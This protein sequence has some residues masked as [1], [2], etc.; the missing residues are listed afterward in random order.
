LCG[1]VSL[2]F[3][4]P[5]FNHNLQ[6]KLKYLISFIIM[7]WSFGSSAQCGLS[8]SYTIQD[9]F[10]DQADTTNI[11][12]LVSGAAINDLADPNQGLCGVTLKFRHNFMKEM[13]IELISPSGQKITLTG[14]NINAYYTGLITWDV[15][16]VPMSATAIPDPGFE[17]IW[18]N[19]QDWL[20]LNNYTGSYY[21]HIGK[22]EDF[23][24]GTVNGTWTLRCID[25]SDGDEGR[26][27]DANLIFCDDE[28][29]ICGECVLDPGN[30]LNP[31]VSYCMGD[32]RLEF[33]VIKTFTTQQPVDS[34]YNYTNVI[35]SDTS[36]I[37]YTDLVDLRAYPSGTYTICGIQYADNQSAIL[38]LPG[39]LLN[40][41]Q[42][43]NL[44]FSSG[45]C[46]AVSDTCLVVV[47][48]NPSIPIN[49][50][51][52]ICAGTSLV[53]DGVAYDQEGVYDI[54]I[55]NGACDSL[56]RLDLKVIN[57][58]ANI[59]TDRDSL[60]CLSNVIAL[61]GSNVGDV[62]NDLTYHWFT[63][64]GIIDTDST[65]FIIDISKVGTYILE[66]TG[67]SQGITCRDSVERT[68]FLDAS[69]PTII[70]Q[71]DTITCK[72]P[73][74]IIDITSNR[75]IVSQVWV[76]A[77]GHLFT[78]TTDG[79]RTGFPGKYIVT[80]TSDN[81]CMATDSI[82]II[83]D[84]F[85]ENP[86]FMAD[87]LTC[88]LDSVQVFLMHNVDRSY[89]YSWTGV[90]PNYQTKRNPYVS[91]SGTISVNM[92]DV[93][94]GCG[95]VFSFDIE[96]DREAPLISSLVV[97]T[98]NCDSIS[99]KP[100]IITNKTIEKYF[101]TGIGIQFMSMQTS[102]IIDNPG[103]YNVVVTASDNGC[104]AS[105]SF[106]VE[107]DT[108]VPIVTLAVDSLSCIVDTVTIRVTSNQSLKSAEWSSTN[109]TSNDIEPKV[110]TPDLY[111]MTYTGINGCKGQTQI[112]V[113]NSEDIP[114]A[115]YITDSIRCGKDSLQL[116]QSF[117]NG[118][119]SYQ[120]EGPNLLEDDVAE[121]RVLSEG[122]YKVTI[123]NITT[124]CKDI[125][126][127]TVV[128]DRIYTVA[129]VVTEPL[130]CVKDS[131]Q[132][133]LLNTDIVS[134]E[135]TFENTFY[136]DVQSPFINKTGTYYFTFV[137]QKNCIT[138]DSVVI[139]RNDTIPLLSVDTPIIKCGIDSVTVSGI[140]SLAGTIFSWR[141][142]GFSAVGSDVFVYEGGDYKMI[143]IAP[144]NCRDSIS[145]TI[146]YDT[147][148]P[149]FNISPADTLTCLR[150][151]IT[152]STDYNEP[153][154][155]VLWLPN[156]I[157]NNTLN[158]SIPGQY[159]A[160]V[161]A[162]NNCTTRDTINVIERKIFPMFNVTSTE[163]NC[164][165]SLSKIVVL[166]INQY[167]NITWD[168]INNPQSIPPETL[169]FD[170]SMP[171]VYFFDVVNNDQCVTEG[172]IEVN[173]NLAIPKILSII[174]DTINCFNP[175]IEI[176]V[177]T[178]RPVLSFRWLSNGLDTTTTG[179]LAVS[180]SG[181]YQVIITA[182]NY[183]TSD[184]SI[185]VLKSEDTPKYTFFSDTLTCTKGKITIGVNPI[186]PIIKYHWEGPDSFVSNVRTPIIF[187]PG[188]YMV[189]IT[190]S[191]GC[192]S[193][194]M[195]DIV[196]NIS[197]PIVNIQDTLLLP[198]DTSFMT[199]SI[200][201]PDRIK[202]FKW[203]Y[204]SGAAYT[205]ITPQTNEI[206]DYTVR[207]T[208]ENGCVTLTHFYVDVDTRPPGF[209]AQSDTIN[210][211]NPEGTLVAK[212]LESEV[213]YEWISETG[214]VYST[215]TIVTSEPGIYTLIV[216]NTNRCRDTLLLSLPID[217][218]KPVIDIEIMGDIQCKNRNVIL[219]GSSSSEGE[220]LVALWSTV[221]GNI[222]NR[223]TDYTIEIMDEGTFVFELL[224]ENNGCK[225]VI[226][227]IV[228]ES[229]QQFTSIDADVVAPSC[230][231]IFDGSIVLTS[232]N[233]TPPY[234][235]VVNGTNVG[236][237]QSFFNL[238]TAT[239][240]LEITD[241]YGCVLEDT[242]ILSDGP[243]LQINIA[244]EVTIQFGDSILL[245]PEFNNGP[246][247]LSSLIWENRDSVLC[248]GCSELL[249]SPLVNTIYTITYG[250]G[251]SCEQSVRI[252]VKV[253]NDLNNA[254]PNIFRPKS[255]SGNNVFYIPQARGIKR[256]NQVAIY[257]R[258]AENVFRS[259][260]MVPGDPYIGWDGTFRG[261]EAVPG[262]YV[263]I[264]EF[265]LAD[266]KI[267]NYQ[268]DITLIR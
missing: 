221:D 5:F 83:E 245:A 64:D 201:S 239:Y 1:K 14:G 196:Q 178:D 206:G 8:K 195:I 87:T 160:L 234:S 71:T 108:L 16:F 58:I 41:S 115:Q 66:V 89:D 52:F 136:A 42:L 20:S 4:F 110:Y 215:P 254:I 74:A 175:V 47:I 173:Q 257:D 167:A 229:P 23:D 227:K 151:Q 125:Q 219:D 80:I 62:V 118:N 165:D 38:P 26:L 218:I 220:G 262:V 32:E 113:P 145:F 111:Q 60:S 22:L 7:I 86:S 212:S 101:W 163:I 211:L 182:D 268:G 54:S 267:W 34:L 100:S 189:T 168:N 233:G 104:T 150:D 24:F 88:K 226:T 225:S 193:I 132:I 147:L 249:V 194:D 75:P 256:I 2:L 76:S 106:E 95:N 103:N 73:E 210:C 67:T 250:V 205:S 36:I 171:G 97:D 3:T 204:P 9:E 198:C 180:E 55:E 120:W 155:S 123:T 40:N 188:K 209:E 166:P 78:S 18:E 134:I 252:L 174:N 77:D 13:F 122:I 156:N 39:T 144:N 121:P 153:Q 190:G 11:S 187:S 68:I 157:I 162:A 242:I 172:S 139:Y 259:T 265:E 90:M 82:L 126:Q 169:S 184:T 241:A 43:N 65:D 105:A 244:P 159:I 216:S 177:N 17:E 181:A 246:T 176:G 93:K 146:G 109:F 263:L 207:V 232:L 140:S 79:I 235:I 261:K 141:G 228:S 27:L 28:N 70:F 61:E 112:L 130:D 114:K 94:N 183:C 128:D 240:N 91:N 142:D 164:R 192:V 59:E 255:A 230:E 21:P 236:N 102:P 170:V 30:I 37:A 69:N 12:I 223:L 119:Y 129:Q 99:V 96:E 57:I 253:N 51:E 10:N 50:T 200:T 266:G 203:I 46:A 25:F 264:I 154:S 137:N 92:V 185:V 199:L 237:T 251:S 231:G 214:V 107:K 131:V 35:F 191:N 116:K 45:Y 260:E 84:K 149:V 248:I 135:Y 81:G 148:A 161:T 85:F 63:Y 208:G 98:I 117:V 222:V 217:T 138:S 53:I 29:I 124:G 202:S 48:D 213:I 72:N 127:L 15:T 152:L 258:W 197:L 49:L 143:G 186:T 238:Q 19:D 56:I 6:K 31:N 243:D 247:G 224:N 44:F 158:V 133:R 33:D 179:T